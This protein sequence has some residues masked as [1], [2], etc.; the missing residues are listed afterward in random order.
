[1]NELA[2]FA[3][4]NFYLLSPDLVHYLTKNSASLRSVGTLEDLSIGVWLMSL[5]V[6]VS[7]NLNVRLLWLYS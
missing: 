3:L 4:G 5:Q 7:I 2:P 1:M 6:V